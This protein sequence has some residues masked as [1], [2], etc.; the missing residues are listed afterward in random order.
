MSRSQVPD[1]PAPLAAIRREYPGWHAFRSSAGRFWASRITHRRRPVDA[2]A[3]WALTVDADDA[4]GLRAE[5]D[6]QERADSG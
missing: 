1:I 6:R 3:E 2:G 4:D 5:L